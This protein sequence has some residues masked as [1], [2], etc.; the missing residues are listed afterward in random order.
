M[1]CICWYLFM[2]VSIYTLY[3]SNYSVVEWLTR[4]VPHAALMIQDIYRKW[5]CNG[6]DRRILQPNIEIRVEEKA[7]GITKNFIQLVLS[8]IWNFT[9]SLVVLSVILII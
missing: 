8:K 5:S 3:S 6:T 7:A 9:V 2:Y 1:Y 4:S